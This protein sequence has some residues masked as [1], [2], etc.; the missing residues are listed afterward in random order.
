M[1]LSMT[2]TT[3]TMRLEAASRH[4]GISRQ[5]LY[6]AHHAGR[7]TIRKI[8]RASLVVTAEVRA[9]V[10]AQALPRREVEVIA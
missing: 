2:S 3:E 9:L 7:L 4:F 8:G 1:H 5:T 10:T 6:R